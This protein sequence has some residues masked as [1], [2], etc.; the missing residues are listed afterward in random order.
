MRRQFLLLGLFAALTPVSIGQDSGMGTPVI[1][2]PMLDQT[3]PEQTELLVPPTPASPAPTPSQASPPAA[4]EVKP[5]PPAAPAPAQQSVAGNGN[6]PE[7][8]QRSMS[9]EA[10]G[11]WS[12][13][14]FTPA[15][16]GGACQI[17][18][19]VTSRDAKQVVLVMALSATASQEGA[20]VQLALPLGISLPT[21]VRLVIGDGYQNQVALQRCTP[22]GCI[23][24]GRGSPELLAAMKREASGNIVVKNEQGQDISLPFSLNGFTASYA[25]M[26]ARNG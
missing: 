25:A 11:N 14:C 26:L 9:S 10:F 5:A 13:E 4:E 16:D 17:S 2:P 22:Q 19:R 18:H 7:D 1:T 24:E 20:A 8:I 23:V 21:G 3:V 15:F 6:V 12:L